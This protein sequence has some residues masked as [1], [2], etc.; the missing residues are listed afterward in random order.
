MSALEGR[1]KDD[2]N[3]EEQPEVFMVDIGRRSGEAL[4]FPS[5]DWPP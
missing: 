4:N 3:G 5:R 2:A 1:A